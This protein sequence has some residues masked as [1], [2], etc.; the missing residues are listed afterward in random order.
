MRTIAVFS[1][2]I[3]VLF[4]TPSHAQLTPEEARDLMGRGINLG[5]TLEP[6]LEGGWNNPPAE[7]AYFD[8]YVEAGFKT[9]RIP[10]RWDQHTGS[11]AP[12]TVDND[13]L[14][15]VDSIIDWGLDR[16]LF[17]IINAHHEDW[18]KVDYGNPAIRARFDSIWSQVSRRYQNKSE[19]LFFEMINEPRTHEHEGLTQT[20]V[21]ELND[22]ILQ[23]IRASNP[24]RIVIFSGTGWTSAADMM[25]T[26]V[27]DDNYIMAY[28]HSYDPWSF[29]GEGNG[30][31]GTD[32]DK[33]SL[34]STFTQVANWASDSGVVVL[35]GEFGAIHDC[36]FN[37]RMRHYAAYVENCLKHNI[38]FTVW[39]DGGW[40]EVY[41]RDTDTW[42]FTKDILIHATPQSPTNLEV[43]IVDSNS[44]ILSW[45]NRI[46]DFDTLFVQR[47]VNAD[48]FEN[49]GIYTNDTATVNDD[50][51][52]IGNTYYY[53]II[54]R[55]TDSVD[56][57]SYPLRLYMTPTDR[58]PY[59]G[60]ALLVPGSIEA[61]DYDKGG[62]GLT[63]H[64]TTETNIPG[65]YRSNEAVDIE[66][67]DEGGYHLSYVAANEWLEYTVDVEETGSYEVVATV[68]SQDGGGAFTVSVENGDEADFS[69][70]STGG[71]ET[72]TEVTSYIN[73]EAGE[74]FLR[75]TIDKTPAF[76]VDKLVF[77]RST[78]VHSQQNLRPQLFPN[79]AT[80]ILYLSQS[81]DKINHAVIRSLEGKTI[82]HITANE[83]ISGIDVSHLQQGYYIVQLTS[84]GK[85]NAISFLKR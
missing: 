59:H 50:S 13:F 56:V 70:P 14:N 3:L 51:V 53:R 83:L 79:P 52:S 63:F 49:I 2:I 47:Q 58:E 31:W 11:T 29:A 10:I 77:T 34:A 61:E 40:F 57:Y 43:E 82:K 15:R 16:D 65:D 39:D 66:A 27:P 76:N 46:T 25:A 69:V 72:F 17:V 8:A 41:E 22:R 7:E 26:S 75:L 80:S 74:Q 68:A 85:V 23:I 35:L 30:T 73:L 32:A 71:W 38:V 24:T 37:S 18:F 60:T 33:M 36:D 62:E 9:V 20:E 45:E 64:E 19:K 21:E 28:F 12:Y 84:A 4:F 42:D 48:S 6:P 81:V 54:A 1:A 44:A 55:Y 67:R 78:G 5:N